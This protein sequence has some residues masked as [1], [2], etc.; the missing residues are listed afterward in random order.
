MDSV[1]APDKENTGEREQ[2]GVR[3]HQATQIGV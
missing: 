1:D 2:E 3:L